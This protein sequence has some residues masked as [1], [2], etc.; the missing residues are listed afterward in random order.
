MTT[1]NKELLQSNLDILTRR[2]E[3][4]L[5]ILH[6]NES[7]LDDDVIINNISKSVELVNDCYTTILKLQ[8]K[9]G[10]EFL[11][12]DDIDSLI[13]KIYQEEGIQKFEEFKK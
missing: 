6:E 9:R 13:D 2:Y 12:D 4:M 10:K 11:S 1:R 7:D 3:S 8:K 5:K